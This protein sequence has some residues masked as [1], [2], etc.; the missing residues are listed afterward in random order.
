LAADHFS[1]TV[2]IRLLE[3]QRKNKEEKEVK[4][5]EEW[6]RKRKVSERREEIHRP[7]HARFFPFSS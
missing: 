5:R 3:V 2:I 6:K 4:G 7:Q 1:Y